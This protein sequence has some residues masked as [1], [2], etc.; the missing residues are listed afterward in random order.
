[1]TFSLKMLSLLRSKPVKFAILGVLA[2][3]ILGLLLG[4]IGSLKNYPDRTQT[5]IDSLVQK[6]D[7]MSQVEEALGAP[8]S[9]DA[10]LWHYSNARRSY[11]TDSSF[12]PASVGVGF[13]DSGK[14]ELV[15]KGPVR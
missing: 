15:M 3:V 8:D 9:K 4:S 10:D 12:V 2:L 1:M 5:E 13:D 14:V 7:S 11:R 6:G